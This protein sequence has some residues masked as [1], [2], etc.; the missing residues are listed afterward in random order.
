MLLVL[1]TTESMNILLLVNYLRFKVKYN[2]HLYIT[3]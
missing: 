2:F 3:L 1:G